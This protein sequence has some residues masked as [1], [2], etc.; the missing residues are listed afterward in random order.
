MATDASDVFST[1]T[2]TGLFVAGLSLGAVYAFNYTQLG[3]VFGA[4]D[5]HTHSDIHTH[6]GAASGEGDGGA[7][8][9]GVKSAAVGTA[10]TTMRKGRRRRK[11]KGVSEVGDEGV[12]EDEG[13]G[14]DGG[15]DGAATHVSIL[16][17]I[18]GD[19]ENVAADVASQE[20]SPAGTTSNPAPG[21]KTQ[22]K[23]KQKQKKQKKQTQTQDQGND[24]DD[25]G[26]ET[27]KEV[28]VGQAVPR[29]GDSTDASLSLSPSLS[30]D[31]ALPSSS[32]AVPGK[33]T[34]GT[35]S[36]R[37]VPPRANA[38]LQPRPSLSFDTDSSW[39]HV[40]H[41]RLKT[42]K[43]ADGQARGL[44]DALDMTSSDL[45]STPSESPVAD[46]MDSDTMDVRGARGD[47]APRTLA[48]K[49]VPKPRKTAVDDMLEEPDFPT[50]ARVM[51]VQPP[52]DQTP[53]PGFSWEDYGDV[54]EESVL[55]HDTD[56]EDEGEWG[57]VKSR[58]R[59]PQ[60]TESTPKS[61]APAATPETMT[62]KQR[63]NARKRELAKSAKAE[64][65]VS[66]LQGLANHQRELERL[67]IIEQSQQGG[68]KR[69][70]GGM[71]A[72]VDDRGN[73]VWE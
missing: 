60:T 19:F 32:R 5:T 33:G 12:G 4:G 45:A 27:G 65:E 1:S 26:S 48:E 37:L 53:I 51:R 16:R 9:E 68:G 23:K 40:D 57:V 67:R 10:T 58:H 2:L 35:G 73:L 56:E 62:K 18:P 3:R 21:V 43:S 47:L 36:T 72:T 50:I 20:S 22:K 49:L 52:A 55:V 17:V 24:R 31:K 54:V 14:Q 30:G 69:P 6:A 29:S 25:E 13:K 28:D 34:L 42:S 64:A 38:P 39:T 61:P 63:Q 70:S 59:T 66:R 46:R 44:A 71:H 8:K 41:R 7:G 11:G 15:E